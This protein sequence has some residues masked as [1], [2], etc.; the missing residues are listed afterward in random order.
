ML[1]KVGFFKYI[2]YHLIQANQKYID[3]LAFGYPQATYFF[4]KT[5]S[6]SVLCAVTARHVI[7]YD[8][9]QKRGL[10]MVRNTKYGPQSLFLYVS[11]QRSA[12]VFYHPDSLVDLAVL[13]QSL[14]IASQDNSEG[15]RWF[16]RQ[17]ILTEPEL[18]TLTVPRPVFFLGLFPDSVSSE[19]MVYWFQPGTLDSILNKPLLFHD[20]RINFTFKA[21][22][23]LDLP[24]KGGISGSPVFVKSND[25]WKILGIINGSNQTSTQCT[26][27]YEILEAIEAR[28]T[29]EN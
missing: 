4:L 12:R 6:L 13:D 23:L 22:L 10:R 19:T 28:R 24:A 14:P 27:A 20:Q 9:A 2:D 8:T 25:K 5:D 16:S 3:S 1:S 29:R 18:D 7:C 26:P 15:L 21:E 17:D 11:T